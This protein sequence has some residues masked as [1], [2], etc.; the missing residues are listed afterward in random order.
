MGGQILGFFILFAFG[1]VIGMFITYKCCEKFEFNTTWMIFTLLSV[2]LYMIIAGFNHIFLAIF[3]CAILNSIY[4]RIYYISYE[5]SESFLIY[6]FLTTGICTIF[7]IA[8][9]VVLIS[10]GFEEMLESLFT[11]NY[12]N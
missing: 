10:L 8:C 9:T 6:I 11:F 7:S 1:F 5:N 12:I 2:A 4:T 3:I